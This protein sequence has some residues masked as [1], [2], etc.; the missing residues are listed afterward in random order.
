MHQINEFSGKNVVI[1]AVQQN[2]WALQFAAEALIAD[3]DVVLAAV[4]RTGSALRFAAKELKADRE[5]VLAAVTRDCWALQFAAEALKADREIV[6]A[7]VTQDGSALSYAAKTLKADRE[8]VLAA[9]TRT[10]WALQFAAKELQDDRE[11]VLAAVTQ[12][13]SVLQYTADNALID[14][15]EIVL[16]AVTQNGCALGWALRCAAE[17][18]TNDASFFWRIWNIQKS[19]THDDY[20]KAYIN[21]YLLKET[22]KISLGVGLTIASGLLLSGIIALPFPALVILIAATV[23][24]AIYTFNK[25][26]EHGYGFFKARAEL[27]APKNEAAFA[28]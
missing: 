25:V 2:G 19:E 13:G 4:T 22:G 14:D 27:S 18:L 28:L 26:A 15:R 3:K 7:A 16:A 23:I 9:V 24:G 12:N 6:L 21:Q 10:G 1:E 20:R 8:I 17:A 5:I 11:I